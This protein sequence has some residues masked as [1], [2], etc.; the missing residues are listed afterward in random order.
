MLSFST[1]FTSF[2][3]NFLG[4]ILNFGRLIYKLLKQQSHMQVSMTKQSF[5][6]LVA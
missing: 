5:E 2:D 1:V 6:N 4:I 3:G